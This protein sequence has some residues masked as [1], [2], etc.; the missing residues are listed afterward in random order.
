MLLAFVKVM[1]VFSTEFIG[2]TLI[3]DASRA[4]TLACCTAGSTQQAPFAA[5]HNSMLSSPRF[6]P[7]IKLAKT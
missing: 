4:L 2:K 5:D 3:D 6:Y 7:M 1:S